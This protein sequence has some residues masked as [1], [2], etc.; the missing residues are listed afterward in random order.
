M[1][2]IIELNHQ[3]PIIYKSALKKDTNI[4]SKIVYL[5]AVIEL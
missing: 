1:P 2:I 4:I 3:K 5:E